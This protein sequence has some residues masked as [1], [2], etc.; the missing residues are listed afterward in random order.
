MFQQ[1]A[2]GKPNLIHVNHKKK[3]GVMNEYKIQAAE[4]KV[5]LRCFVKFLASSAL[6]L[7]TEYSKQYNTKYKYKSASCSVGALRASTEQL[8]EQPAYILLLLPLHVR[9]QAPLL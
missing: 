9:S 1:T 7:T 4:H 8:A 2:T 6:E 5:L 3:K